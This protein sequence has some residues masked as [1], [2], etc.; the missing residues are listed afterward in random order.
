M[1]TMSISS[2]VAPVAS[3]LMIPL[4]YGTLLC[5]SSCVLILDHPNPA[6]T[7]YYF[8][9]VVSQNGREKK[10]SKAELCSDVFHLKI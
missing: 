8:L 4:R 10:S 1:H 3:F 6:V 7:H 9:L 5:W 2:E